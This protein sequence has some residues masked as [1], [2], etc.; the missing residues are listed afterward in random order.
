MPRPMSPGICRLHRVESTSDRIGLGVNRS[1]CKS[2]P[3]SILAALALPVKEGW[4]FRCSSLSRTELKSPH[5]NM[6]RDRSISPVME[7]KNAPDSCLE[8]K[9]RRSS[10]GLPLDSPESG[11]RP[12]GQGIIA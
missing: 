2:M 5:T 10:A 1:D 8:R 11:S 6:G 4:H 9:A 12:R 7:A 3:V